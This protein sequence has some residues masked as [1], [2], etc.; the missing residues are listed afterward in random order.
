MSKKAKKV[1]RSIY[2]NP[3]V[4]EYLDNIGSVTSRSASQEIEYIVNMTKKNRENIDQEA[5]KLV[6]LCIQRQNS[7]Q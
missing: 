7:Q 3:E 5:L 4:W 2:L 1:G 6:D